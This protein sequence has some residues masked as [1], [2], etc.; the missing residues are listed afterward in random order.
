MTIGDLN[1]LD[2]ESAEREL[3][4]C[5]GSARWARTLA[6]KRPFATV[7]AVADDAD[8]IWRSLDPVD[9]LEAFAAHPRIGSAPSGVGWSDDEQWRARE[10]EYESLLE[11]KS[12]LNRQL[13]IQNKEILAR[14]PGVAAKPQGVLSEEELLEIQRQ[15]EEERLLIQQ[16]RQDMEE[17]F[18]KVLDS[19]QAFRN[20]ECFWWQVAE[21]SYDTFMIRSR[22]R[23]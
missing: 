18:K 3:L 8:A 4:R 23:A 15:L 7:A 12:E 5:C 19:M 14:T 21:Y 16:E 22:P 11:E 17:D 9:W 6:E 13:N 10:T 20:D 1:A 2:Q